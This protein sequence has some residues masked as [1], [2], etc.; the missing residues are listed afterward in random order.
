MPTLCWRKRAAR[1]NAISWTV[2]WSGAGAPSRI[3]RRRTGRSETSPFPGASRTC[4]TSAAAS[5]PLSA[6]R[7]ATTAVED[8]ACDLDDGLAHGP[9]ARERRRP[10][11]DHNFAR[12]YR[13]DASI[14][15][16][17]EGPLRLR[18]P[19]ALSRKDGRK[20]LQLIADFGG[21]ACEI[22]RRQEPNPDNLERAPR[23]NG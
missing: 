12:R 4:P 17:A 10:P 15:L 16:Y 2:G 22:G 20:I 19:A 9:H 21:H 5:K 1:S 6:S 14:T 11:L 18:T 23:N 13:S 7:P 8:R 3:P